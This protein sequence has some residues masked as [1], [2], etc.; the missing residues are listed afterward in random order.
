MTTVGDL[1]AV[2]SSAPDFKLVATDL[3]E[4]TVADYSGQTLILNIFPSIDTSV[5]ADSTRKF[6]EQ[7]NSMENT[8]V[9]CISKD[10]PF[11]LDRFCGAEGL[12]NVIPLSDFRGRF[13]QD[14]GVQINYG[15]LN[16]LLSRAVVVIKEDKIVYTEQVPEIA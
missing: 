4:K 5:C 1:P 9:L 13:G 12:D 14:Y 8:S 15:L 16:G 11:A 2:G 7:M 10:L 6:N 3:T